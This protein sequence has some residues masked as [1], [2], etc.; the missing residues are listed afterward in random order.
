M[1]V[2]YNAGIA[3]ELFPLLI[4]VGVGAMIDF[5]PLLAQPKMA[6]LGA[7]GQFG[8]FGALILA[9]ALGFPLNE[10]ASIGVIGAIDG[11][12]SDFCRN[13][14]CAGASCS[15]CGGGLLLHESDPHHP[16]AIDETVDNKKRTPDPDGVH[17]QT[18]LTKDTYV[19]SDSLNACGGFARTRKPH[20]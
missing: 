4:F 1:G 15:H 12:T 8:I 13:E 18:D 5:S 3:T 7:A 20:L 9:I 6:L 2:L 17:T 16:A 19:L 10:A 11:P 14:T